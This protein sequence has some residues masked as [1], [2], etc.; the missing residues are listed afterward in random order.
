MLT[1]L[2]PELRNRI[3]EYS[4]ASNYA[5]TLRSRCVEH[6]LTKVC[7]RLR[8]EC[9][10][11][12][13]ALSRFNAHLDDG[14]AYPLATWL[15][16]LGRDRTL[17]LNEVNIWDMHMLNATLHGTESTADMLASTTK[18]GKRYVLQPTGSWVLNRGWY[19]KDIFMALHSM[20]LEL[21]NLALLNA[22]DDQVSRA[23]MTSHFAIV[24]SVETVEGHSA[25]CARA[26]LRDLLG[27]LGFTDDMIDAAIRGVLDSGNEGCREVKVRRGRRDIFLYFDRG[28]LKSIRQT[29]V[30]REGE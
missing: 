7:R 16:S 22:W 29:F 10:G 3:Y 13:Y 20:G 15:K 24:P 12:Y 11:M 27:H 26:V 18:D 21:R 25:S 2:S 5:I 14:P 17:L 19:L 8:S 23:N 4:F 6:P 30:P 9:R 28:D 1:R